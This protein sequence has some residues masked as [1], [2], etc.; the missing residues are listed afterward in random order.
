MDNVNDIDNHN[1]NYNSNDNDNLILSYLIWETAGGRAND[2]PDQGRDALGG[3]RGHPGNG[4]DLS[5]SNAG[6]AGRA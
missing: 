4:N 6:E 3:S 1:D 5:R 2:A